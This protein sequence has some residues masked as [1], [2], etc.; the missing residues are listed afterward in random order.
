MGFLF[1]MKA[2]AAKKRYELKLNHTD[3]YYIYVDILPRFASDQVDFK[4]AQ[5]VLNK[6]TMFPR[7]LWFE[8]ANSTET[9]WDVLQINSNDKTID[10]REFDAPTPP[11]GWKMV[12]AP[13]DA[14]SPPRMARPSGS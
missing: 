13:K 12:N 14:K 1:G 11:P 10:R 7:R 9:T 6:E 8:Q 4:Q 2:T 3:K 5:I